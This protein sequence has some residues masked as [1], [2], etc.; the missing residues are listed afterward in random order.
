LSSP[1]AAYRARDFD[2]VLLDIE[3]PKM[4]GVSAFREMRRFDYEMRRR[5]TPIVAL[6]ANAMAHQVEEYLGAGME[7]HVAK[8]VS[9][10]K[11]LKAVAEYSQ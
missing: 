2:L 3:M 10:A 6:T 7:G 1:I 11:L 5:P 4:D 9:Q 8:P